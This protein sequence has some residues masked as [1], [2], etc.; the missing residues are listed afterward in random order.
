MKMVIGRIQN[1][2]IESTKKITEQSTKRS[3]IDDTERC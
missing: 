1:F 2:I 3:M